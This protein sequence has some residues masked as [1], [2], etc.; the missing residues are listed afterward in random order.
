MD[1][2]HDDAATDIEHDVPLEWVRPRG[3][4]STSRSH[5]RRRSSARKQHARGGH[6]GAGSGAGSG[7]PPALGDPVEVD[8]QQR[9]TVHL[10]RVV[11][12][13]RDGTFD[14]V[15]GEHGDLATNIAFSRVRPATGSTRH[16]QPPAGAVSLPP[17]AGAQP[18]SQSGHP[19][20]PERSPA[21]AK[22]A[23]PVV[24]DGI[25]CLMCR[26]APIT[27]VRYKCSVCANVDFCEACVN[28]P[29]YSHNER[30]LLLRVPDSRIAYAAPSPNCRPLVSTPS[31]A[32]RPHSTAATKARHHHLAP[33]AAAAARGA[34]EAG[35]G[36]KFCSN[37]GA[38]VARGTKFCAECGTKAA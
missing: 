5:S 26:R 6:A 11:S 34:Q 18:S 37:C 32:A 8:D 36:G 16:A 7:A 35:A 17:A 2:A 20:T 14:V 24:H 22:P 15:F 3:R 9:G 29:T 1:V 31:A 27:G 30:H 28:K 33:V 23:G 38:K 12:V 21:P 13:N 4:H 10:G 25:G 19:S